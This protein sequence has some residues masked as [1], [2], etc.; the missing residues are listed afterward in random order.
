MKNRESYLFNLVD[1]NKRKSILITGSPSKAKRAL[2]IG[3]RIEVFKNGIYH[4]TYYVR[5][6]G[7]FSKYLKREKEY[8]R[9]KQERNKR[10]R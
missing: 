9:I 4:E 1:V 5:T 2:T 10:K 8:H 6:I 7:Y 3:K